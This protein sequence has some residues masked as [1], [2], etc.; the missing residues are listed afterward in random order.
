[1][2]WQGD[3]GCHLS[4]DKSINMIN[5][6]GTII[7]T[8]IVNPAWNSSRSSSF[9]SAIFNSISL[10]LFVAVFCLPLSEVSNQM[11][12]IPY[13]VLTSISRRVKRTYLAE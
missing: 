10:I 9:I 12:T 13:E 8:A 11:G 5:V 6:A 3:F 2:K 1:M 7:N 4:I